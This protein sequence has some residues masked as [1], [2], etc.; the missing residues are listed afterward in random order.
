MRPSRLIIVA[1]SGCVPEVKYSKNDLASKVADDT[2]SLSDGRLRRILRITKDQ[3][4]SE[5]KI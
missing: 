4:S 3:L 5:E 2:I 1:S